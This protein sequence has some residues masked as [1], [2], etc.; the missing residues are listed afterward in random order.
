MRLIPVWP[1]EMHLIIFDQILVIETGPKTI[2]FGQG[3]F[4]FLKKAL[5]LPPGN[6]FWCAIFESH[7]QYICE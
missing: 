6:P 2:L 7:F 4:S 3:C 1:L 5:G